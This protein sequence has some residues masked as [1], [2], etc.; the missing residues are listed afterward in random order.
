MYVCLKGLGK[1]YLEEAQCIQLYC[2]MNYVW[3]GKLMQIIDLLIE[4]SEEILW[5]DISGEENLTGFLSLD[6]KSSI[7]AE[8]E[9]TET[10]PTD[11]NSL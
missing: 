3:Y 2:L 10:C 5:Y 1:I 11:I 7:S 4:K 8:K 9:F 6:T